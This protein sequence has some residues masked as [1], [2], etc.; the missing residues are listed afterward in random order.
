[1]LGFFYCLNISFINSRDFLDNSFNGFFGLT[2]CRPIYGN[3]WPCY[4]FNWILKHNS[5]FRIPAKFQ[6][7]LY[8]IN[9]QAHLKYQQGSKE[10]R[11]WPMNSM[12]VPNINTQNYPLWRFQF[13]F[14]LKRLD[15]PFN[16]ATNQN[17]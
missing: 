9:S 11:Q 17:S 7:K 15:T 16:I 14:W 4:S 13:N 12:R 1:M 2:C 5:P 6:R 10:I 8:K 3:N